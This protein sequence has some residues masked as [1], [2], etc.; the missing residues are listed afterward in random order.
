[1]IC[2]ILHFILCFHFVCNSS[3]CYPVPYQLKAAAIL[4]QHV[5]RAL[6]KQASAVVFGDTIVVSEKIYKWLYRS[7]Q[8]TDAPS[9]KG[10][11]DLPCSPTDLTVFSR[12]S[13]LM[14]F[15][16]KVSSIPKLNT[17][18]HYFPSVHH[19]FLFPL[20]DLFFSSFIPIRI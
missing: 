13:H 18:I 7:V 4:L 8:W 16:N 6:S 12:Y 5:M 9:W 3:L 15:E 1:M 17:V 10:M 11:P 20:L 2:I 14:T 19:S